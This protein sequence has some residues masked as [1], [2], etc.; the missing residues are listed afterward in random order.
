[1][2]SLILGS[3]A[4]FCLV[5]APASAAQPVTTGET[6][7][8]PNYTVVIVSPEDGAV[9]DG[10]P[11]AVVPVSIEIEMFWLDDVRLRVDG[12]YVG[13]C[14]N[15]DGFDT[16]GTGLPCTIE[17]TLTPGVHKLEA[18][19]ETAPFIDWHEITVEVKDIGSATTEG[20]T[21]SA[22]D[23][24]ATTDATTSDTTS[25]TTSATTDTTSATTDA[26]TDATTSDTTSTTDAADSGSGGDSGDKGCVCSAGSG[27]PDLLGLALLGLLVP[28]RRRPRA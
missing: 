25:D 18:F 16:D 2:R 3:S 23:T 14:P 9:L 13:T 5:A 28:W 19:G 4:L 7:T 11:N 8:L 26:T 15:P 10:T 27:G 20:P 12:A 6:D 24:D 22:T 17:A 1:M 21:S